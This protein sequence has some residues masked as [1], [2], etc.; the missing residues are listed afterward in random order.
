MLYRQKD[1]LRY[2]VGING[3]NNKHPLTLDL[4]KWGKGFSRFRLISEGKDAL[5]GF[6]VNTYDINS[7]WS[8]TIA[9]KG[10]FV[11]QFIR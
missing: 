4:K 8:Y 2:I 11:I 9:P 6:D 10:G 1:A 7:A 3:T 5:M